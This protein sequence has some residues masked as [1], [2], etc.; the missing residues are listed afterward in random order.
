MKINFKNWIIKKN[1]GKIY[2]IESDVFKDIE[3]Y[4]KFISESNG[5]ELLRSF[6]N[7]LKYW[8]EMPEALRQEYSGYVQFKRKYRIYCLIGVLGGSIGFVALLFIGY[9]FLGEFF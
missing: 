6:G 7:P 2:E 8:D 1:K 9:Y 3:E 4:N 5:V